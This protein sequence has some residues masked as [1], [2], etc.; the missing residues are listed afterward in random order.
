L[1]L[2]TADL[3][4]V[5]AA[6]QSFAIAIGVIV[7]GAWTLFTFWSLATMQRAKAE[8]LELQRGEEPGFQMSLKSRVIGR[9]IIVELELCNPSKRTVGLDLVSV[10]PITLV[11]LDFETHGRVVIDGKPIRIEAMTV[12]SGKF[13]KQ[14]TRYLRGGDKR[15]TVHVCEVPG[16]GLYMIEAKVAYSEASLKIGDDSEPTQHS[17]LAIEQGIVEVPEASSAG[18]AACG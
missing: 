6:A 16:P 11:N 1:E 9:T 12:E 14:G 8:L 18:T 13:R 4:N 7:G 17:V 2:S 15:N 5:A 3:K 10:P